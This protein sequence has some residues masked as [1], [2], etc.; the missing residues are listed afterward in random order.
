VMTDRSPVVGLAGG[1]HHSGTPRIN[2]GSERRPPWPTLA[3][4]KSVPTAGS[5]ST[6]LNTGSPQQL[7]ATFSESPP[8]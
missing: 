1:E 3:S 4:G 8:N 6:P 7:C 5:K 2:H